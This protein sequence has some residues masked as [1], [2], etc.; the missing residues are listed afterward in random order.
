MKIMSVVFLF[1]LFWYLF[2]RFQV[3]YFIDV[4]LIKCVYTYVLVL[5]LI[6]TANL[7]FAFI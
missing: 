3:L 6:V 1:G 5:L 2:F 4:I 7:V